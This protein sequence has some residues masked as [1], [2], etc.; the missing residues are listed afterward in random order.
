MDPP[1]RLITDRPPRRR[2][3]HRL[4]LRQPAARR[5]GPQS[6]PQDGEYARQHE[7]RVH[8]P[9]GAFHAEPDELDQLCPEVRSAEREPVT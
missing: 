6:D 1:F 3:R 9:G 2:L 4:P 8:E 5:A 7:L